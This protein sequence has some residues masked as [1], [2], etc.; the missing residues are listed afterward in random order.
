MVSQEFI[1]SK[2]VNISIKIKIGVN[3]F[4]VF[5]FFFIK[6]VENIWV[7]IGVKECL[8][9]FFLLIVV[10]NIIFLIII[11]IYIFIFNDLNDDRSEMLL[12]DIRRQLHV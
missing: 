3:L 9:I 11:L 2:T 8:D 12:E 10:N 1:V 7:L 5:I 4:T 6:L